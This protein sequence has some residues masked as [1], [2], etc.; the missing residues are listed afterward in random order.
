MKTIQHD[1]QPLGIRSN[2]ISVHNRVSLVK[3]R[4]NLGNDSR[5]KINDYIRAMDE[6]LSVPKF[7]YNEE[8]QSPHTKS[9]KKFDKCLE[10]S[11]HKMS[12]V[13]FAENK[14]SNEKMRTIDSKMLLH[15]ASTEL[16][17]SQ[18][19]RQEENRDR[20]EK[21]LTKIP[22]EKRDKLFKYLQ[23]GRNDHGGVYGRKMHFSTLITS[24]FQHS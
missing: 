11:N 12:T 5:S 20:R 23:R 19:R 21:S 22:I 2:T 13:S 14:F 9:C 6:R 4:D 24:K 3:M 18:E 15:N 8:S 1:E 10:Q 7:R 17:K 16:M